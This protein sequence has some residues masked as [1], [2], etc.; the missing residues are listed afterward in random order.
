MVACNKSSCANLCRVVLAKTRVE[1]DT[2]VHYKGTMSD[3]KKG[4][5]LR[6][7]CAGTAACIA[8]I[9]TFHTIVSDAVFRAF[10]LFLLCALPW[11]VS[12]CAL[13]VP[14]FRAFVDTL[15]L[16]F[17]KTTSVLVWIVAGTLPLDTVKVRMQIQGQGLAPGTPL[18]YKNMVQCG[19]G[20][21]K[22]ETPAALWKG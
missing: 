5:V 20:I 21:I 10:L 1:P 18:P 2:P 9:C 19:L 4:G 12:G 22:E 8:E 17:L 3:K 13:S 11:P 6:Y 7:A 14:C 16:S 15:V